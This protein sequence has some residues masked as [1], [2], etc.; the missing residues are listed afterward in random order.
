MFHFAKR[1]QDVLL[2]PFLY[3]LY[4]GKYLNMSHQ[5][6]SQIRGPWPCSRHM[7][8]SLPKG[9]PPL[10]ERGPL[11]A[12]WVILMTSTHGPGFLIPSTTK[13]PGREAPS[14]YPLSI[15]LPSVN[16]WAPG[17][18]QSVLCSTSDK[19]DDDPTV[20]HPL[21]ALAALKNV[22]EDIY[23]TIVP[24]VS[25][26]CSNPVQTTVYLPLPSLDP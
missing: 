3:L 17:G 13:E 16:A 1:P 18:P 26:T 21:A 14:L 4:H 22:T 7:A 11:K 15:L 25:A 8:C 2:L 12:P 6:K 23:K 20:D 10:L 9:K 24:S 19:S 5:Q